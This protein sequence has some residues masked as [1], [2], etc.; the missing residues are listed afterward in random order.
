MPARAVAVNFEITGL[1]IDLAAGVT[2]VTWI[3]D[4]ETEQEIAMSGALFT[5]LAA[6]SHADGL[7]NSN[8]CAPANAAASANE[9]SRCCAIS[10]FEMFA[11]IG[12]N[13]SR[14]TKSA[15]AKTVICPESFF[16]CN[17]D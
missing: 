15:M 14:P 16:I 2:S 7:L 12:S 13:A 4:G 17:F 11:A 6:T 1:S 5:K 9:L 8:S 10:R 3:A